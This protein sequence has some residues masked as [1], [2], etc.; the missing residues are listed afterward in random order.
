MQSINRRAM[1]F[2]MGLAIS[3]M[4]PCHSY[5]AQVLITEQEAKL[6][7]AKDEKL[8]SRG[9]TRGPRVALVDGSAAR[10]PFHLQ[11][12]F[13]SFGGAKIDVESL[14]VIPLKT[15]NV[16]LTSRVKPFAEADGIDMPEAESPAGEY[17]VRVE[18]KD[19]DGRAVAKTFELKVAQ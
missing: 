12:K 18:L 8:D 15:P 4:A 5:A 16:D 7:P 11:F 19:T 14:H 10:S 17:S 2:F 3:I 13:Q 1:A 6:P 9:I